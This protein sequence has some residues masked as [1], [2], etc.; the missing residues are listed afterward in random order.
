MSC[1]DITIFKEIIFEPSLNICERQPCKEC[2]TVSM[3]NLVIYR[4]RGGIIRVA[5]RDIV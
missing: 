2:F 4:K 3:V 1:K 5:R